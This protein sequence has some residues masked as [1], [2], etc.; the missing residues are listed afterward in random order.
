MI[1]KIFHPRL[2][3]GG[4]AAGGSVMTGGGCI[5]G[6]L[7]SGAGGE[8]LSMKTNRIGKEEMEQAR[9]NS[10]QMRRHAVALVSAG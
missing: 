8:L 6:I 4:R 10:M 2:L 5:G 1:A 7:Y 3:R 9:F